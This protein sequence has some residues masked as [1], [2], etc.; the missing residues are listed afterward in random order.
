V[1]VNTYRH[2]GGA[3]WLDEVGCLGTEN[4]LADCAHNEW[5]INDCSHTE[6]DVAIECD[7]D[8]STIGDVPVLI[9]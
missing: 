6:E 2:V 4:S 9:E 8:P 5:G 7:P 3:N 1:I